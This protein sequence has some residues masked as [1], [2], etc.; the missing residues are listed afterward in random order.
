[1]SS[2]CWWNVGA[3]LRHR[4]DL[5]DLGG[6]VG[7]LARDEVPQ[8]GADDGAVVGDAL[9]RTAGHEGVHRDAHGVGALEALELAR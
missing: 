2:S 4:V 9:E 6:E 3:A 5:P 1:M 8:P 7:G